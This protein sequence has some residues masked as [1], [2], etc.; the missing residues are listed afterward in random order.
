MID[1]AFEAIPLTQQKDHVGSVAYDKARNLLYIS[2]SFGDGEKP[3][4]HVW[5]VR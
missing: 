3:L 4:I 1:P 2:E 5:H